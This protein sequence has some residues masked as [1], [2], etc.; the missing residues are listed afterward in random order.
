MGGAGFG[1]KHNFID[2][3]CKWI[4]VSGDR[5]TRGAIVVGT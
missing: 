2:G 1:L 5:Q 4:P 3:G